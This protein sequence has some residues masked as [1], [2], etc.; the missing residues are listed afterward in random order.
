MGRADYVDTELTVSAI[1]V[2]ASCD[3]K[4]PPPANGPVVVTDMLW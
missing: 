3:F 1:S 4:H 2:I